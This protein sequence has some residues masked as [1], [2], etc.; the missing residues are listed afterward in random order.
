MPATI[1]QLKAD[2]LA[3]AD[4][5]EHKCFPWMG[6]HFIGFKYDPDQDCDKVMPLQILYHESQ[7]SGFVWQHNTKIPQDWSGEGFHIWKYPDALAIIDHPATCTI[8]HTKNPGTT[9][10]I[11]LGCLSANF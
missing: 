5:Y 8:E 10:S 9:S 3:E 11:C 2:A 1:P 4:W 7:L 6:K